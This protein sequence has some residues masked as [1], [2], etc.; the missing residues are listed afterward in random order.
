[1]DLNL[2]KYS[3]YCKNYC[4]TVKGIAYREYLL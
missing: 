3:V 2:K 4:L 1:M